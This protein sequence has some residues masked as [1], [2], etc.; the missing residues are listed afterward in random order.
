MIDV[1]S[2]PEVIL[3]VKDKS[4]L[5]KLCKKIQ[6]PISKFEYIDTNAKQIIGGK[7]ACYSIFAAKGLEFK[8]VVVYAKTMTT[9]QK[10]VA[11]TRAM[12]KLYYCE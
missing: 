5:E 8:K 3:I 11:C 7:I 2:R 6:K 1:L 12:E 10:I 4:I 9:N